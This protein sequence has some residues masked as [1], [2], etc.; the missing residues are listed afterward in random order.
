MLKF[1]TQ[2]NFPLNQILTSGN[3]KCF[4]KPKTSL[5]I[6]TYNCSWL[7]LSQTAI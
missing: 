6:L 3:D 5:T 4:S 1:C 7:D 2:P